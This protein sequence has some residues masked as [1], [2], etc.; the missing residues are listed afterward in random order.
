MGQTEL[1][2]LRLHEQGP[3]NWIGN[4]P[5]QGLR[6]ALS[7]PSSANRL[8]FKQRREKS[9]S[10]NEANF[11][12]FQKQE[13]SLHRSG[14]LDC[15]PSL[16]ESSSRGGNAGLA[17]RH[18]ALGQ[19]SVDH[20]GDLHE[21]RGAGGGYG[22]KEVQETPDLLKRFMQGVQKDRK[23]KQYSLPN[24]LFPRGRRRPLFGP[25]LLHEDQP[26]PPQLHQTVA[27]HQDEHQQDRIVRAV[28]FEIGE[29]RN[30]LRK[31]SVVHQI[32][33]QGGISFLHQ[34]R[35]IEEKDSF[36]GLRE[37]L[38]GAKGNDM[39]VRRRGAAKVEHWEIGEE[40]N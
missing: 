12:R 35:R 30:L 38:G 26:S 9:A 2:A 31:L 6:T 22:D 34:F 37:E 16:A 11:H 14:S 28:R 29:V 32:Q 23:S 3:A 8:Y 25:L 7:P 18:S 5:E 19:N 1:R 17:E 40:S 10:G 27:F 39:S 4:T 15:R 21:S 20:S 24:L 36:R 13:H 33:G